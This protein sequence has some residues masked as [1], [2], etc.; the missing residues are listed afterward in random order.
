[1]SEDS[2]LS[3][4]EK[5]AL[6][7]KE[8]KADWKKKSVKHAGRFVVSKNKQIQLPESGQVGNV[9][10]LT[11]VADNLKYTISVNAMVE[12]ADEPDDADEAIDVSEIDMHQ[13]QKAFTAFLKTIH[14]VL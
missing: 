5:I 11:D 8:V 3:K 2:N 6:L 12:M 10:V 9:Y 7:T 1:M 4:A 14:E 13:L